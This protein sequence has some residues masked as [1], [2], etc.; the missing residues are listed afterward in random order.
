M[1]EWV[2]VAMQAMQATQVDID[3]GMEKESGDR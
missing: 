1:D 2:A 3:I